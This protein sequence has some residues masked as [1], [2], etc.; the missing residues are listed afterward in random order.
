MSKAEVLTTFMCRLSWNLGASTSWNPLGP[1]QGCNGIALPLYIATALA[2]CRE[3][4]N[5]SI[6]VLGI[7]LVTV[8][9]H[10]TRS[11]CVVKIPHWCIVQNFVFHLFKLQFLSN[12]RQIIKS[13]KKTCLVITTSI[14]FSWLLNKIG[15]ESGSVCRYDVRMYV[16]KWACHGTLRYLDSPYTFKIFR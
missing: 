2:E 6:A 15:I 11:V 14:Y 10:D 16:Q 7:L 5:L 12:K 9:L 1:L 4:T 3:G 13:C 8:A